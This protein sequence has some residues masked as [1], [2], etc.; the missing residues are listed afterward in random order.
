MLGETKISLPLQKNINTMTIVYIILSLLVGLAIGFL[1]AKSK[2]NALETRCDLLISNLDEEKKR[3]QQLI[4][5]HSSAI[6][7]LKADNDLAIDK[8]KAE[9]NSVIE[10]MTAQ[11]ALAVDKIKEEHR[12]ALESL[13]K[14]QSEQMQQQME[15]IKEQMNSA[16]EKILKERSEQLATN[17]KEQLSAILNPLKTEI[18]QMKET[19]DK[20]GREHATSMERLDASIKANLQQANTLSERADK[21]ALALTGDNKQQGNFGELKLKTLLEDMGLEEGTQFEEQYTMKDANGATIYEEDG[22]RLIPDVILHFP[23]HRD[24]II[25]SK[26]SF[27]AY[28]KYQNAETEEDKR[29][30]L[31]EHIASVRKHVNELA[32]KDYSRF[33]ERGNNKL[34]FVLM[35][36]F[37]ESALQLA[38]ANEPT[39]W[40][41]AYDKGVII[42]G[43]QNLYMMLRV[44]EMT[45]KQVRQVEN[46][47]NIM[48]AANTIIERVQIFYERLENVEKQFNS[49]QRA[50]DELKTVSAPGGKS[51]ATSANQLLKFGAKESTKHK[52]LSTSIDPQALLEEE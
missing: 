12:E 29:L 7:R 31:K 51:I 4:A 39:L 21:L 18:T 34:D 38:L 32:R 6:E 1:Y 17:N 20:S 10:K 44:L 8:L 27:T 41:E 22:H 2:A 5:D 3:N 35:Y 46:Q 11:H 42:S 50:F 13:K 33:I 36:V 37:Q 16:S 9:N 52:K 48:K 25:D 14:M 19:V 40:K 49:A 23:D 30:A 43:S 45:W 24:V 26:M 47:E 15:L 28:V